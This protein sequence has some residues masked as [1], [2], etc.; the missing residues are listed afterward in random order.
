M[1]CL[2]AVDCP[3]GKETEQ[4]ENPSCNK[5]LY[6]RD[7]IIDCYNEHIGKSKRK[8]EFPCKSHHLIN[9]KTREGSAK[10]DEHEEHTQRLNHEPQPGRQNRSVPTTEK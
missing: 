7:V 8:Q 1:R 4:H 9:S 10:P 3:N 6:P 2:A 5:T